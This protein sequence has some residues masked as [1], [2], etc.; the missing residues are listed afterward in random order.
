MKILTLAAGRGSRVT[1][2]GTPKP[3]V[4]FRNRM[5]L[6]WS[7]ESFHRCKASGLVAPEDYLV[8]V[9][10]KHI[11]E[12][13]LESQGF[14]RHTQLIGIDG[15]TRGP[16]ETAALAIGRALNA[17]LLHP[18]EPIIINDCD[19]YF[20]SGSVYRKIRELRSGPRRSHLL[21][22]AEKD[23]D[24]LSWS[25]V[26]RDGI[27]L[28]GVIEKP[29]VDELVGLDPARGLAGIY[30]WSSA[31]EFLRLF[32]KHCSDIPDSTGEIY[33]SA[34]SNLAIREGWS[35]SIG[36]I[37]DF[38]PL[39]T[40]NQLAGAV[41]EDLPAKGLR[42]PGT[43]FVDIDGTLIKHDPG[44][45]SDLGD[46]LPHLE[47]LAE[48]TIFQLGMLADF[49]ISIVLVSSR[50]KSQ[51]EQL[52]DNLT[53][54]GVVYDRL[55]LG[56]SGGARY[57]IND[58][59]PSLP[60]ISTAVAF[61]VERNNPDF[62]TL[63]LELLEH[64]KTKIVADLSG[65]SGTSAAALK[66]TGGRT[67]IRKSSQTT[68]DSRALMAYQAA[69]Y[70]HVGNLYA[71]NVPRV[72]RVS[73]NAGDSSWFFDTEFIEGAVSASDLLANS[74][75]SE[76]KIFLDKLVEVLGGIYATHRV[77]QRSSMDL[78]IHTLAAK[79]LPGYQ[80][81]LNS[82]RS[83]V[84][85]RAFDATDHR[86]PVPIISESLSELALNP[87]TALTSA[88]KGEE[89]R[90]TLIHGDLTFGNLHAGPDRRPL[91]LDPIGARVHPTFE[92]KNG[93]LG[94]AEPLFDWARAELSLAHGYD[95]W[96]ST[97]HI[98]DQLLLTHSKAPIQYKTSRDHLA[99]FWDEW[100]PQHPLVRSLAMLITV[101][102]IAPYKA[103]AGKVA[104]TYRLLGLAADYL[105]DI[106][107]G[108]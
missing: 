88:L 10:S 98:D 48:D 58:M 57:L 31:D 64:E 19:H 44:F 94:V 89:S 32:D 102:R 2:Q 107:T 95:L 59:K 104:E 40:D 23:P 28:R 75:E 81:A 87:P 61:N 13:N 22:E 56:L 20:D 29:R 100:V 37:R 7:M 83:L 26:K 106:N 24:D 55:I 16:A 85:D 50:P 65:E 63:S 103:K 97:L 9:Q 39:G 5:I 101:A 60:G 53:R 11:D 71:E 78:L 62:S 4:F 51:E 80:I 76:N 21:F 68:P 72:S 6:E 36:S 18:D 1:G 96:V 15:P 91:L 74:G 41:S 27:Q 92:F 79:A 93:R 67:V 25:F 35:V 17:K 90:L 70:Q 52:V 86:G 73:A 84:G 99:V 12:F 108:W 45:F 82:L 43:V 34:L 8:A 105:D 47:P 54:L 69:W 46:F 14:L 38:V 77:D 33:I 30:G 3:F 66:L 42:E 49:G